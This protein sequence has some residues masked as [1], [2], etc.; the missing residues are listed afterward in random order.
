MSRVTRSTGGNK[1][2]VRAQGSHSQ[3]QIG[4]NVDMETNADDDALIDEDVDNAEA[5]STGGA[6]ITL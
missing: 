2:D 3:G 4:A 6:S 5:I 1:K